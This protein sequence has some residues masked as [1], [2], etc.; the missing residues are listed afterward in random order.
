MFE[1]KKWEDYDVN[2][3]YYLDKIYDE[4]QKIEKSSIVLPQDNINQQLSLF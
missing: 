4:I 3:K 2:D 1:D